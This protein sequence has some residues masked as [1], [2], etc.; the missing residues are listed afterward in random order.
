MLSGWLR[1]VINRVRAILVLPAK[2]SRTDMQTKLAIALELRFGKELVECGLVRKCLVGCRIT[3][4]VFG[5]VAV[6]RRLD[7]N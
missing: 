3:Q 5:F 4:D 6:D 1:E 7:V 2:H